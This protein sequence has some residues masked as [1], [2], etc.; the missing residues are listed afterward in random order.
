MTLRQGQF[1]LT[2]SELLLLALVGCNK[3]AENPAPPPG[4]PPVHELASTNI[5]LKYNA[6]DCQQY[7]S[8]NNLVPFIPVP[9]GSNVHWVTDHVNG[10]EIQFLPGSSPVYDFSGDLYADSGPTAGTNGTVYVYNTVTIGGQ[11]CRNTLTDPPSPL[12]IVMR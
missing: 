6:G 10:I 9:H 3:P 1:S 4:H 7:D 11:P 2:V 12:G 8:N 5:L